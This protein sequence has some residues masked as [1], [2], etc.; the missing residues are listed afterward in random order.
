MSEVYSPMS[1]AF[2]T[3]VLN[4]SRHDVACECV[5]SCCIA[6]EEV[7]DTCVG[8]HDTYITQDIHDTHLHD[9]CVGMPCHLNTSRHDVGV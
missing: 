2:N 1:S 3:S 9:T 8:L 5:T 4:T 7:H 6:R